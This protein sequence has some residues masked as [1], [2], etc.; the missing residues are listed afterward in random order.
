MQVNARIERHRGV[1]DIPAGKDR[2]PPGVA[3][4]GDLVYHRAYGHGAT[5]VERGEQDVA[6]V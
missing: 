5:V 2:P 3:A 4:Q 1:A 6:F